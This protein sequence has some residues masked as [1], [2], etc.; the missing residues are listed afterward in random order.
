MSAVTVIEGQATTLATFVP[1][2]ALPAH[3]QKG[4]EQLGSNM[5][6]R[7]TVPSLSYEGKVWKIVTGKEKTPI[8]TRNSEG[9]VVPSAVVRVVILD[10]A[11][12]RGRAYYEQGYDPA[13]P[14]QPNCWSVDGEGPDENVK[15]APS[16]AC[17]TCPM[18][19]K[20]SKILDGREMTA[21][22]QHRILCVVPSNDI[23]AE[24]LRLKIAITSDWDKDYAEHGWFAFQQYMDFLKANGITHSGMVVT[25][26]KF[27]NG[28][29][30]PKLVFGVDRFLSEAEYAQMTEALKSPKVAEIIA[31]K[32][33]PAGVNGVEAAQGDTAPAGVAGKPEDPAHI[34]HAGTKNEL[35]WD[36]TEWKK[37]WIAPAVAAADPAP[38]P[39]P[40]P[41]VQTTGASLIV[42]DKPSDPR[43]IAHAGTANELWWDGSAWVAPWPI[44]AATAAEPTPPPPPAPAPEP[45]PAPLPPKPDNPAYIAH[46]GTV[47]ELWW[48]GS[49]WVKPWL[50]DA[51]P[52]DEPA[53]PSPDLNPEVAKADTGLPA[54]V[55]AIMEKWGG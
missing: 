24:P 45:E 44:P 29:S 12:R 54:E 39:A 49:E 42:R 34:A 5:P 10:L 40:D 50:G 17:R 19:A 22:A 41:A 23:A 48:D 38:G 16:K 55:S 37:P 26:I 36:G 7:N 2:G 9:D 30:Y 27:D 15:N 51:A 3:L 8:T 43:H 4:A 31:D 32:F 52:A 21:C 46:A 28:T 13:K 18:A 33:T 1:G 14:A 35:W 25:K 53:K 11:G 6:D 20:G 47:N